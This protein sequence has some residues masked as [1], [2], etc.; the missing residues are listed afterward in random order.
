[1]FHR[2][3][4]KST[5]IFIGIFTVLGVGMVAVPIAAARYFKGNTA[6]NLM[7]SAATSFVTDIHDKH[8]EQ[9]YSQM[10]APFRALHPSAEFVQVVSNTPSLSESN[11]LDFRKH[12]VTDQEAFMDASLSG[13]HADVSF[14]FTKEG[15]SWHV[16]G[17]QLSGHDLFPKAS[18]ATDAG[19]VDAGAL[20][21]EEKD[22]QEVEGLVAATAHFGQ[23]QS[24][25]VHA[26]GEL[27]NDKKRKCPVLA[28]AAKVAIDKGAPKLASERAALDA[29]KVKLSG[30]RLKRPAEQAK[31]DKAVFIL[32]TDD[33]AEFQKFRL[34]CPTE[35]KRSFTH[36]EQVVKPMFF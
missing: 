14:T 24:A 27:F 13:T 31:A 10:A 8:Y 20:T 18:A 12:R 35:A 26:V 28:S 7:A 3:R 9:A 22:D 2:E 29:L 19:S 36:L 15:E 16:S 33:I 6:V 32:R 21:V 25:L 23:S 34:R 17:V 5:P 1:M 4:A 30:P 11:S